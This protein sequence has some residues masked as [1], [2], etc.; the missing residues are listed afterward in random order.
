MNLGT[1]T[2]NV[3]NNI[4]SRMTKNAPTPEVG[5]GATVLCWSDR[6]AATVISVEKNIVTV[7]HDTA[8]RTDSN[9]MSEDQSYSYEP[10]P[11]GRVQYFR[12]SKDGKFTE[13]S[14]N[15]ETGRWNKQGSSAGLI[16]GLRQK[17]YD[18]SF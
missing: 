8:T 13:V 17:Y 10:N 18:F 15:A 16:L 7:Q 1:Q 2:V 12:I 5:M 6:Q 9:G 4:Y 3:V 14:K 11:N